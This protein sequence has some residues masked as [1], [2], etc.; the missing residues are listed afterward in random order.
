MNT[1]PRTLRRFA[2]STNFRN[3]FNASFIKRGTI[4]GSDQRFLLLNNNDATP[5]WNA[6]QGLVKS[7][8]LSRTFAQYFGIS[9]RKEPPEPRGLPLIGTTLSLMR[10]GGPQKLHEYVDNRHREL[11]PVFREQIGPVQGVFVN[12]PAEYRKILSDLAGNT[13]QHF[14]PEPW[15]L[16]N[17]MRAQ[18]RG[19]LFMEGE[20]WWYY[21]KIL[22]R[23]M[24]K[25]G[26]KVFYGPCQKAADNLTKEWKTY[27]QT[28]RTIPNLEH[29]LYQWSIEVMLAAMIGS[30]WHVCEPR[31]RYDIED[32]AMILHQIF[33]YTSSLS[34]LPAKLAMK[35][36][37]PVWNK[38][39][40]AADSVL[41]KVRKLVPEMIQL[42]D[43]D[44][45]LQ[46]ILN[47]DIRG[48]KAVRIICDFVI[49]AG[50]TTSITMQWVLLLLSNQPEL[51]DRL[52]DEIKDLSLEN[53]LQH[54][55]LR[56][57]W[58]ETLRLYPVAPFITRI[59]PVDSVIGGY[60]VPKGNLILLS[61][62]S[63]GRD[64]NNYVRPN[65]FWPERWLRTGEDSFK[66]QGV[67][68]TRANVPFAVGVRNCIG[69]RLA[70]TQLSLTLAQL[71][72]NFKIECEN[73][74]KIKMIL[75][76]VSVPSESIRLK[77]TDR[78]I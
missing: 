26:S 10:S 46:M 72:K 34:M 49:A 37:L 29:E 70:E 59:L 56:H 41:E 45:I 52:F 19:L 3:D 6:S 35:L 32:I 60:F 21:R 4:L 5:S 54:Q 13:P 50:D 15:V 66:Y 65:E 20:E 33:T 57:V 68:D 77:L 69:Q 47:N 23:I 40:K 51:Q 9:T 73:R 74:D 31:L 17:E 22:N 24:L 78:K 8:V 61:L 58:K 2:R 38:F 71:I 64:E 43:N 75:R 42:S 1:T 44:G 39:V 48:D 55:L 30:Q 28:D 7:S 25:S 14:L 11:G 67:K 62:Y 12:S 27:S 63:S 76:M 53:L 16:Y 36:R 18:N